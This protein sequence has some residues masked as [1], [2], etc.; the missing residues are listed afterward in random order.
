[1]SLPSN[2]NNFLSNSQ[3]I[4]SAG[5]DVEK[6]NSCYTFLVR[7]KS[8]TVTIRK[9]IIVLWKFEKEQVR[10]PAIILLG[11][12]LHEMMYQ[13]DISFHVYLTA[14]LTIAQLMQKV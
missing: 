6:R 3:K 13:R 9:G 2:K 14:L 12:Y 11:M 5:K 1:M 10:V 7:M 4:T 8:N